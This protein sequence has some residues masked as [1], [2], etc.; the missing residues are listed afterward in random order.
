MV[1]QV[2]FLWMLLCF[3]A[4]GAEDPPSP[5]LPPDGPAAL[6]VKAAEHLQWKPEDQALEAVGK[7]NLAYKNFVLQAHR[8]RLLY[9]GDG[10]SPQGSPSSAPAMESIRAFDL[11]GAVVLKNALY[12]LNCQRAHYQFSNQRLNLSGDPIV[13]KNNTDTAKIWGTVTVDLAHSRIDGMGP[14]HLSRQNYDVKGNDMT[15]MFL[16]L[17]MNHLQDATLTT[18]AILKDV[19][20]TY[21]GL[22]VTA[23]HALY[24]QGAQTVTLT[25]NV[26]L[27]RQNSVIR[28]EKGVLDLTTQRVRLSSPNQPVTG[29]IHV[30]DFEKTKD[31]PKPQTKDKS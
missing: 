12:T 9:Q 19:V 17:D 5:T 26:I 21:P 29:N 23:D 8:A 14:V 18:A 28:T 7:V 11:E 30:P 24:D 4:F 27:T 6:E 2:F 15:L 25:S 3:S 31:A 16:P 13:I 1:F 10:P 20:L 22:N